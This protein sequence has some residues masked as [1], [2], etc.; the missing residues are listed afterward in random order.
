MLSAES[1]S[2]AA[3][4]A[5]E[6]RFSDSRGTE[7]DE[8]TDGSAGIFDAGPRSHYGVGDELN[9]FVL[10][11]DSLVQ[12]LIKMKE[13]FAFAFEQAMH[14]NSSPSRDDLRNLILAQYF[15][16][17][18]VITSLGGE[19]FLFRLQPTLQFRDG[20]MAQL[21][22]PVEIVSALGGFGFKSCPFKLLSQRLDS[23]DGLTLGLPASSHGV[24][25]GPYIGQLVA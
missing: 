1:K 11:D 14:G 17:Q 13:L 8:R 22:G 25:F 16:K 4:V 24:D 23:V 18:G 9:S 19:L 6:F 15:V 7:E 3:N 10:T 20:S 12:D 5:G 2:A 21:G